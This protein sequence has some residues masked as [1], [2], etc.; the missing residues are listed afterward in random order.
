MNFVSWAFIALFAVVFAARL[1]IGRR[2]VEAP[3]V[4]VLLGASLLFYAWHIPVYLSVLLGITVI[5]Y[6]VARAIAQAPGDTRRARWWL[7]L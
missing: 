6:L 3:Y 7:A 2:K 1:T 5:D 4:A